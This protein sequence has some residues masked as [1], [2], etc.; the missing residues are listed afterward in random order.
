M[1]R[2]QGVSEHLCSD[3]TVPWLRTKHHHEGE[4]AAPNRKNE[5][6]DFR[7]RLRAGG[8]GKT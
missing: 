7:A 4:V 5:S 2:L 8:D 6:L 1:A 3:A